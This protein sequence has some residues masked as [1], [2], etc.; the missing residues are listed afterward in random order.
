MRTWMIAGCLGL[1]LIG[2]AL[3]QNDKA[4]KAK[5]LYTSGKKIEALPLYEELT[6]AEP[7]QY[8]YF[9]RLA[10]CLAA[11]STQLGEG[12]EVVAIRTR[13]RDAAKRA[14]EL[15]ASA[16]YLQVMADIDPNKPLG[17]APDASPGAMLLKEAEKAYGAGD[18]STAM[19]KYTAAADADPHLYEAALFAGDTAYTQK[20][21]PTAAK[22][23][24]RAISIDPN[25]E[26]AY[27]YWGDAIFKYGD[28]PLAAKEKFIDAIVAEP[29]SRMA[30]QGLQQW[31][32]LEKAVIMPPQISIPGQVAVDPHDPKKIN[33]TVDP[34]GSDEKKHPGAS[35]WLMYSLVVASY[36]GD[37]FK[38]EFPNEKEYRDSLKE[39]DAAFTGVVEVLKEKKAP[40][41]KLDD[42]LRNLKELSNAGMIDCFILISG[43][44][45][46]IAQDYAAY[47][48][49]TASCCTTTS[50]GL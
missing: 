49:I 8:L 31:A 10:D 2:T 39:K 48:R 44:D 18:Y 37:Q 9:Q 30:W 26:T 1:G 34:V 12:S 22:W 29:Y 24:A 40:K 6:K 47:R 21:L 50:T 3:A 46:G 45:D 4:A 23:F 19:A 25:R 42:S 36:H 41:E 20:D 28:D 16:E 14:V 32:Q 11:E 7:Q 33:I 17:G 13:M 35:A 5:A 27:R 38:K 43:A 15:G